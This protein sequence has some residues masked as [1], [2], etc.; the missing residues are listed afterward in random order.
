MSW[1]L[2]SIQ[3]DAAAALGTHIEDQGS[4]GMV[5]NLKYTLECSAKI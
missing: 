2:G 3:E 5:L 4:G 1:L